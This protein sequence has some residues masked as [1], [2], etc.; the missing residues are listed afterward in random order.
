[1]KELKDIE[2]LPATMPVLK[3]NGAR[4][5][6]DFQYYLGEPAGRM[7]GGRV[8]DL[9]EAVRELQRASEAQRYL[10][11]ALAGG[12]G[13]EVV[14]PGERGEERRYTVAELKEKE[15]DFYGRRDCGLESFLDWLENTQK[16]T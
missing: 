1:M 14:N 5:E 2:A 7:I 8:N 16:G 9:N 3:V 12:M 15:R 4:A 6:G 13:T 10:L 11:E